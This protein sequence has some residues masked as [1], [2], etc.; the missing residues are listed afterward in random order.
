MWTVI[1]FSAS[2]ILM[3]W[4]GFMF[5]KPS[6]PAKD[7][8]VC[9]CTHIWNMHTTEGNEEKDGCQVEIARDKFTRYGERAGDEYVKCPCLRYVGN[10]PYQAMM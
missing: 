8:Y 7:E 1:A 4:L 6:N 3:F 9:S 2:I 5:G 10:I